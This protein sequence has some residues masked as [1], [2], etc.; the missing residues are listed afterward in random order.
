M[1]KETTDTLK[2]IDKTDNIAFEIEREY[3]KDVPTALWIT[4]WLIKRIKFN[5]PTSKT[6]GKKTDVFEELKICLK[7]IEDIDKEITKNMKPQ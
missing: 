3:F 2:F 4:A 1:D 5:Q 7:A 6:T